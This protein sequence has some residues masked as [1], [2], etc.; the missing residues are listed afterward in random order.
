MVLSMTTIRY[1]GG[2]A[3]YHKETGV[4]MIGRERL[5]AKRDL[6]REYLILGLVVLFSRI[7]KTESAHMT[8]KQVVRPS[9]RRE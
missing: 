9:Q 6:E 5:T 7:T 1:Y 8:D 3:K 2:A 4:S